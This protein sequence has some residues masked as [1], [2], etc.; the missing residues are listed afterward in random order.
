MYYE[1][2]FE[3]ENGKY[4]KIKVELFTSPF[5]N[6]FDF[7][8][9]VFKSSD[10]INWE[11][12]HKPSLNKEMTMSVSEYVEKGRP[13]IFKVVS[14]GEILKTISEAKEWKKKN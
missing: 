9:Y 6:K 10:K 14:Q 3:R 2:I 12:I 1:K 4:A 13:E 7:D 11:I 8:Y 5:S